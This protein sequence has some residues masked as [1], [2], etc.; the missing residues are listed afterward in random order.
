MQWWCAAQGIPWEWSWRP[1]PGVWIFLLLLAFAGWRAHRSAGRRGDA[2][3]SGP[4]EAARE[5]AGTAP[6]GDVDGTDE[7]GRAVSMTGGLLLLWLALDWPLGALGAGYLA[8]VHMV[9]FVLIALA[10]PP[11]LLHGLPPA[12]LDRLRDR[13]RTFAALRFLTRPLVA[14]ALYFGVVVIT[15]WP[16]VVDALMASQGGS[17][18]LDLAWLLAGLLFWWPVAAPVPARP[19][20]SPPLKI[21]YLILATV[22]NTAPYAFLTFAELPFYA[23]YELAPPVAGIPTRTDQQVAG[24]IMKLGGGLVLWVGAGILFFRWYGKEEAREPGVRGAA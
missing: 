7:R 3:T 19:R 14:L 15:H 20:F 23:T 4:G 18:L 17:F 11:L 24:L 9:Q 10:A 12:A 21:G 1:Y 6:A 16:S 8:S 13:R 5:P 22:L 2:G